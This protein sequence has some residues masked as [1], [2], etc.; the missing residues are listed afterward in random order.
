MRAIGWIGLLLF[1]L[2]PAPAQAQDA[3]LSEFAGTFQGS[4]VAEGRDN[5]YFTIVARDLDVTIRPKNGGFDV[6]WTTITHGTTRGQRVV[7]KTET[8][9]FAATAKPT[10]FRAAAPVEPMAGAP[11]YWARIAGR[12]LTVYALSI[13][14]DGAYELTSWAR[15]L[16]GNGMDLTF[17]RLSDG[18][19][20]RSVR[21]KLVKVA[22]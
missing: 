11:Y 8:I 5:V 20:V 18:E 15:T 12:T 22:P 1:A 7:R 17:R 6:T 21:G 13:G 16:N 4:G 9:G 2:L 19:A 14:A 10:V 3:R